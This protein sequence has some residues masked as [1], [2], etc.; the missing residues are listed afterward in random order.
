MSQACPH[1]TTPPCDVSLQGERTLDSQDAVG[2]ADWVIH[3][4]AIPGRAASIPGIAPPPSDAGGAVSPVLPDCSP[5]PLVSP[6]PRA[7][8]SGRGGRERTRRAAD[9]R[10]PPAVSSGARLAH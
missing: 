3:P 9:E 7:P 8:R 6:H 2:G 4:Q 10:T 1:I 5:S